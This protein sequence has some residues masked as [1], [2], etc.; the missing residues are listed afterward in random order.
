[1][2]RTL[3]EELKMV[4]KLNPRRITS[5]G[6]YVISNR[7]RMRLTK[8]QIQA[9]RRYFHDSTIASNVLIHSHQKSN[10]SNKNRNSKK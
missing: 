7:E 2:N 10:T 8:M 9:A 6:Y 4:A 1:M 3:E 5:D